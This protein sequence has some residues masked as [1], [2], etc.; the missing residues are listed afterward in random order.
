MS[1][2]M[3]HHYYKIRHDVITAH[4][5]CKGLFD[6]R[7]AVTNGPDL[8]LLLPSIEMLLSTIFTSP[9]GPRFIIRG[10]PAGCV[11]RSERIT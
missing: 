6:E 10:T 1:F 2:N 8:L 3:S 11:G 9:F 5:V 7:F 4:Y